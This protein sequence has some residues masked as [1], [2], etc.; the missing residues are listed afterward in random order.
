MTL[1]G[2]HLQAIKITDMEYKFTAMP[3]IDGKV[4]ALR[5]TLGLLQIE[6]C[7]LSIQ[8]DIL[9]YDSTTS[10]A[11]SKLKDSHYRLPPPPQDSNS[12][13]ALPSDIQPLQIASYSKHHLSATEQASSY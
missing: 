13:L 12:E 7:L 8:R 4:I 1:N 3:T 11:A 10:R 5:T 2:D 6:V 9:Q